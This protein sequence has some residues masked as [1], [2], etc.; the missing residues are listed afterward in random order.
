MK[1][2]YFGDNIQGGDKETC[3]TYAGEGSSENQEIHGRCDGTKQRSELENG[4]IDEEDPFD[5]N[6][7]AELAMQHEGSHLGEEV[8]GRDPGYLGEGM[9]LRG[10]DGIRRG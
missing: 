6:Q 8:G 7:C 1:G 4:N 10:N 9:E 5:W 3:A 2:C